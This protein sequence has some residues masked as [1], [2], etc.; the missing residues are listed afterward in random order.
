MLSFLCGPA[1][2]P[3]TAIFSVVNAVLLSPLPYA[4]P[5]RVVTVWGELRHRNVDDWPFSN[6]DFADLR[7]EN[8]TFEGLAGL[9]TFRNAVAG[10]DG[11]AVVV[12]TANVTTNVFGVLGLAVAQGRDFTDADGVPPPPAAQ[13]AA[14]GAPAAA[15]QTPAAPATR[16]ISHEFWQRY[17]GGDRSI[18]GQVVSLGTQRI[19]VV[20]ILA[21][22]AELLFRPGT[23]IEQRPDVWAPLRVDFT[24]GN[25]NNVGLSVVG[26]LKQGVTLDQAQ[27]DVDAIAARLRQQFEVKQTSGLYFHVQPIGRDLVANV[28]VAILALMGAVVFV[29]LIACANVANLLLARS[30]ARERELAV[31]AALGAGRGRLIRQLLAESLILAAGGA[32]I[33]LLLAQLGVRLLLSLQPEDL[34]RLAAVS[35]DL[36]V[37]AFAIAVSVAAA[38]LFGLLPA[39]R[40]ARPDLND[41]LRKSGRTGALS[42]G[43]WL[44][45]GVVVAEVVLSFVLLVGCGL[46][47]RSFIELQRID[48]GFDAEGVLTFQLGNLQLND[49]DAAGAFVRDFTS[50]LEAL[51]GVSAAAVALPLPLDGQAVNARWGPL[52]AASDSSLFRQATTHFVSPAYF[53]TLGTRVLQGRTF[54]EADNRPDALFIVIDDL[55]AARAFPGES[56]IGKRLLSRIR[57]DQPETFEVIGV[58]E[59][60]RHQSLAIEGREG[61]FFA[62]ALIGNIPFARWAVRTSGDPAALVPAVRRE[63]AALPGRPLLLDARPMTD[64]IDRATAGTRFTLVLIGVFAAVAALLAIVGLYG[65]LAT[66]VRQRTAEIGVRMAFGASRPSVFRLVV[67]QGLAL[68]GVGVALG[69]GAAFVL[70]GVMRTMLVGVTPTDPVTFSAIAAG[71]LAVAA[72]ASAVPARR[73]SRLEPTAALREE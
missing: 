54:T 67:G 60:Q 16:I 73:A 72:F 34:P 56:P 14:G 36:R 2:G 9:G 1:I 31:R 32:V 61:M 40:S 27:A 70:T 53:E 10:P 47:L 38:V 49:P 48:P 66:V 8:T 59:H 18:V 44:R 46:M 23:G 42:G 11:D 55:L 69:L 41:V 20:G 30:A 26:R 25:R 63:L 6:P 24:Q 17:Y 45:N 52:A 4:E 33:G 15:P 12:T 43:A 39:M 62:G 37:V 58:V 71:F 57:T 35:I 64:Y 50:R 3:T 22:G 7:A 5:E 13:P 19:E 51:P 65:V 68:A 28:R 29:L 21:P